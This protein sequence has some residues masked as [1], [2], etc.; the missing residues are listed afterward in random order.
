[1]NISIIIPCF[2]EEENVRRIVPELLPV[3]DGSGGAAE[4]VVVDDGSA[5]DTAKN[6]S[7]IR[8]G[9]IRLIRHGMNKGLG[10]ALRTGIAEAKNEYSIFLDGDLTFHPNCIP[11]LMAALQ[12]HPEADFVIGSPALAQYAE[13]IPVWRVLISTMANFLYR[14]LL[15]RPVTST[16]SIFR[17]YKTDQLKA[18]HLTSNGFEINAEILFKLVFGGK[19][20]V[21]VPARLTQRMHGVSK[22][23]YAREVRRHAVL[24]S[25]I[26][27]WKFL[28]T[29]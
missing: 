4:I 5:D 19:R 27:A 10:Q 20:F 2:N 24:V 25:K 13:T 15:G 28:G 11:A 16:N 8:D 3:L 29:H 22:L 21:E 18:L 26:L 9:R 14:I 12:T 23:H 6:V 1:M 7:D 17:L